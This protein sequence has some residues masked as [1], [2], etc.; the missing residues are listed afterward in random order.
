MLGF[1][2][3]VLNIGTF[4]IPPINAGLPDVGPFAVSWYAILSVLPIRA[5][6][7]TGWRVSPATCQ[8]R[9]GLTGFPGKWVAFPIRNGNSGVANNNMM[10]ILHA[11]EKVEP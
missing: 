3:L 6:R 1:Q 2:G 8:G 5:Q 11:T 9:H 7:K 4:P 10:K